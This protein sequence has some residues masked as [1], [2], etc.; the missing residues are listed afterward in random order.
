LISYYDD[1]KRNSFFTQLIYLRK[2]GLVIE[3][4]QQFQKLSCKVDGIL[5][6]TLL[7]LFIGT[8]KDN[9]QH[10]VCLFEPTSFKKAFMVGRKVETKNMAMATRR[11]TS[12]TYRENNFPSSNPPQ[13]ARL[14]PQKMDERR[15]KGLFFNCCDNYSKRHK[16]GENKLFYIVCEEE[17]AK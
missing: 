13:P 16:C 12:N 15:T 9:I 17:E 3:N 7:V 1:V 4:I 5:D 6:D 10:E 14:T 2:K 8:L 11:T